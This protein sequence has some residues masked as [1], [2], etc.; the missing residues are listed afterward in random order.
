MNRRFYTLFYSSIFPSVWG[1]VLCLFVSLTAS[2]GQNN[3]FP[4]AQ[5]SEAGPRVPPAPATSAIDTSTFDFRKD[6]S[7]QLITVDEMYEL[8][9]V[10]SP[11]IKY[12]GAISN[13][14]EAAYRLAKVQILQNMTGFVN[15]STGN[16]AILSTGSAASDQ[17]GQIT[18][19]YRA[20][21][22]LAVSIHDLFGRPQ[23]IRLAKANYNATLERRRTAQIELKR[24]LFNLYQDLLLAQR[25]LQIRLRNSQTTLT[26]YRISEV[27]LAKGTITPE[28][29]A[30]NSTRYAESQITTEQAKTDFIKAIYALELLVG[31]PV[32]QLKR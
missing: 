20:G 28:V 8:A 17:L 24:D 23:Q 10:Y 15:Y 14:Q 25:A 13:A 5:K 1:F 16:Q 6:I 26:A 22:N 30:D 18:N 21:V 11:A 27:E 7:Q 29:A 32:R 9:V 2:Y 31:V 12:E 3:R 4:F 19:G